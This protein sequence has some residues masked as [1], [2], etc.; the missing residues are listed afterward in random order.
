MANA[1][2]I[3]ITKRVS[4]AGLSDGWDGCYAI[5]TPA[6]YIDYDTIAKADFSKM[7]K[8]GQNA[9]EM[10]TV[11][12][13]FVNGKIKLFDEDDL[14]DMTPEDVYSS[15]ELADRLYAEIMGLK[16]DPKDVP[17]AVPNRPSQPSSTDTTETSSSTE[18]PKA[19]RTESTET[20]PSS[21][22]GSTSDSPTMT[23]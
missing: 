3:T 6:S 10:Q 22:T 11:R 7:T 12:D 14:V 23:Q 4:L 8:A 15:L 5:V 17:P 18:L 19:S 16:L 9:L 1:P 21:D 2:R 20:L 13:H